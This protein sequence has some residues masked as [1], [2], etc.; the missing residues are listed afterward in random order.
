MSESALIKDPLNKDIILDPPY[1]KTFLKK[2]GSVGYALFISVF[3]IL[4]CD[5][6]ELYLNIEM[7]TELKNKI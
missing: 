1:I 3:Y 6:V 2:E 7:K 5:T 4:F